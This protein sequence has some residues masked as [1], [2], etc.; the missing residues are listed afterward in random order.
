MDFIDAV[1]SRCLAVIMPKVVEMLQQSNGMA[2]E[3][4]IL[5]GTY[6]PTDG[7]ASILFGDTAAC[8]TDQG[9]TPNIAAHVPIHTIATGT[10]Q[11]PLGD[12]RV[13]C[14]PTPSGYVAMV[15]HGP[16]DSPGAAPGQCILGATAASGVLIGAN[17]LDVTQD[18]AMRQANSQALANAI[19]AHV[20]T[21]FNALAAS[22]QAGP[23]VTPPTIASVTAS[24]SSTVRIKS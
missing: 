23:G 8:F 6:D 22:V 16:D 17:V 10:Q 9:D 3:G 20:Q 5:K 18:A 14:F 1:V 21:A 13:K 7:T 19:I 12:E 15:V 4:I 2:R 24:G 11:G